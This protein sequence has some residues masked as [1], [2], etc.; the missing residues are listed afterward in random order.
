MVMITSRNN[1]EKNT[2]VALASLSLPHASISFHHFK[3][4]E[5]FPGAVSDSL[6]G[7]HDKGRAT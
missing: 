1:S 4:S 7:Y 5:T 6:N 2:F 3:F